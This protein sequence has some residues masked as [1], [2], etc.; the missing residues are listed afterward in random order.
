ML[1]TAKG[2]YSN[3]AVLLGFSDLKRLKSERPLIFDRGKG[4]FVFDE[5]GKDYIEAVSCFY[6]AALGFSDEQLVEAAIRQLQFLAD[7]SFRH[8]PHGAGGDGAH[9]KARGNRTGQEPAHLF[10][11]HG[12]RGE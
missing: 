1:Q 10:R 9:R 11:D 7:V 6:C 3:E 8:S 2:N 12:L 5:T 4:I